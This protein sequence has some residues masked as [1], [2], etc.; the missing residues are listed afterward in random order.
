MK[1]AIAKHNDLLLKQAINHY[2][3]SVDMFT[4]LSLYS[5]FEP[6]PINEVVDVIKHKINDLESELAPWRKLG[7]ENEALETQLYALKR[8]LKRMEQ[9]QGEMTNGN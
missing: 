2:R 6:Y 8:Q 3:K 9:R 1:C 4:F 7:R 5:D